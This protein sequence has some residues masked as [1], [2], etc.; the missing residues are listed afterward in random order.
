MPPCSLAVTSFLA[1]IQACVKEWTAN[2]V[3]PPKSR[4]GLLRTRW[5]P[6]HRVH[7]SLGFAFRFFLVKWKIPLSVPHAQAQFV[8]HL[9]KP[10]PLG[11]S[12]HTPTTF[13]PCSRAFY[14]LCTNACPGWVLPRIPFDRSHRMHRGIDAPIDP[15]TNSVPQTQR[16]LE[17]PT[18][19]TSLINIISRQPLTKGLFRSTRRLF[20]SQNGR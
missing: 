13:F 7:T 2:S 9:L 4:E 10:D 20:I 1:S 11:P 14:E 3:V 6:V 16:S 17:A 19:A 8:L 18:P 15:N 12:K 5:R